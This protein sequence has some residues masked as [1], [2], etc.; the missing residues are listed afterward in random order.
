MSKKKNNL[1]EKNDNSLDR[2]SSYE[3]NERTYEILGFALRFED[4][5]E[6][7]HF[8]DERLSTKY[9]MSIKEFTKD[10]TKVIK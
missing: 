10:F 9:I 4:D 8:E 6:M 5:E 7:V 3:Y 1:K 2:Y